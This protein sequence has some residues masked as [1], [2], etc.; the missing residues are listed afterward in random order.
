MAPSTDS[1]P[2]AFWITEVHPNAGPKTYQTHQRSQLP[3]SAP[4]NFE[5]ALL[6][7]FEPVFPPGE[8]CTLEAMRARIK[9]VVQN[10]HNSDRPPIDLVA[11]VCGDR[12]GE[13][14]VWRALD[15]LQ[16]RHLLVKGGTPGDFNF[17]GLTRLSTKWPLQHVW[18]SSCMSRNYEE[19]DPIYDT[20]TSLSFFD[21]EDPS[22]FLPELPRL[23]K[24]AVFES[25]SCSVFAHAIH[26]R[27]THPEMLQVLHIQ[28]TDGIDFEDEY[29]AGDFCNALQQ[30]LSLK[31]L[32]FYTIYRFDGDDRDEEHQVFAKSLPPSLQHL[33]IR[34]PAF[35]LSSDFAEDRRILTECA[36][37]PGWLPNLETITFRLDAKNHAH[38]KNRFSPQDAAN[39][40]A[41]EID[42]FLTTLKGSHP[43]LEVV[44]WDRSVLGGL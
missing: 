43:S 12:G 44:E 3:E 36:A 15:G 1:A 16:P 28:T 11:F 6:L 2:A 10:D 13:G 32:E 4:Q 22:S 19:F 30:C 41:P 35:L 27:M 26:Y 34:G 42:A 14:R 23:R 38:I 18:I 20:V 8:P 24:F 25:G 7:D 40:R 39:P 9:R 33:R 5:H 37:D 29:H 17:N 31:T 21:C